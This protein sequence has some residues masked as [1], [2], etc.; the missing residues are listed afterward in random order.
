MVKTD[1]KSAFGFGCFLLVFSGKGIL[2][3]FHANVSDM[4]GCM[5]T[6]RFVVYQR[7]LFH[8]CLH[9]RLLS[10]IWV[11]DDSDI[12]RGSQVPMNLF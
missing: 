3:Q 12:S 8:S 9:G 7:I 2:Q 4:N 6:H 11:L 5:T 1:G 10:M